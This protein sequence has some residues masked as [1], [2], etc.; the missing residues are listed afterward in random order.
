MAAK[1]VGLVLAGVLALAGA[2]AGR[3]A[4]GP[5]PG[6]D[7]AA[8]RAGG[9]VI[10]LRHAATDPARADRDRAGLPDCEAQGILSEAGRADARAV[11][12][13]LRALGVPVGEVRSSPWC[14]A[15]ETA[16]LAFGRAA[17]DPDL[18]NLH[19]APD[20]AEKARRATA[21]RALLA[22]PPAPGTNA[23]LVGHGFNLAAAARVPIAQ[24]DAALFRPLGAEGFAFAG[25][26]APGEWAA[27][28]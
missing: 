17:V 1:Q 13:G 15:L 12:E 28:R 23:V 18:A 4:G 21:L 10:F 7:V 22:R 16:R 25:R 2:G 3:A 24:G 8:L 20:E 14:R 27:L 5:A 6:V 19:D 9:F 11:G 26:V